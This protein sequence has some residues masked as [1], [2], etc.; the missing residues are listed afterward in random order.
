MKTLTL[1]TTLLAVSAA[2]KCVVKPSAAAAA[3]AVASDVEAEVSSDET[4]PIADEEDSAVE[5]DG[6]KNRK[7]G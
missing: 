7:E 3:D 4:S 5:S 2:K 1:F 6:E